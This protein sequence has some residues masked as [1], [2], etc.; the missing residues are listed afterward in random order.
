MGSGCRQHQ[1]GNNERWRPLLWL[2]PAGLIGN[3]LYAL[4]ASNPEALRTSL[5]LD[6]RWLSLAFLLAVLPLIFNAWRVW[7]WGGLLL[8]GFR[9]QAAL[10]AVLC[11][12]L[13]AAMTPTATGGAPLKVVA[14]AR[15]GLGMSGGVTLAALGGL[16]DACFIIPAIILAA[17]HTGLLPRFVADLNETIVAI[18]S[19][20][21]ILPALIVAAFVLAMSVLLLRHQRAAGLRHRIVRWY[22]DVR[23][24]VRIARDHGRGVFAGNVALAGL[25]WSARLSIF[26]ALAAGLGTPLEPLRAAV[27]QWLC[28]TCMVLVPTPGAIGGAEASFVLVLGRELPAPI[29][30]LAM[31]AWRLVTFYGLNLASIGALILMERRSPPTSSGETRAS[32]SPDTGCRQAAPFPKRLPSAVLRD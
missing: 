6:L 2:I 11:A 1:N 29:L 23:C 8:P 26:A 32:G 22:G 3:L 20:A 7:R 24:S 21:S 12:E 13:G 16:E 15:S 5:E 27:L 14:L 4:A 19:G 10:R 17:W 25:Q 18:P 31:A 9:R 28:F 30:P